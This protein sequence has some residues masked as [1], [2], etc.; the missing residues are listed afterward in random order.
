MS[1]KDRTNQ[2]LPP[3]KCKG[4][5]AF[6]GLEKDKKRRINGKKMLRIEETGYEAALFLAYTHKNAGSLSPIGQRWSRMKGTRTF[7]SP[8]ADADDEDCCVVE[9]GR[10]QAAVRL[11]EA[12]R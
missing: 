1:R 4:K 12:R 5:V 9:V 8:L 2:R 3:L 11:R 6:L 10:T 7:T